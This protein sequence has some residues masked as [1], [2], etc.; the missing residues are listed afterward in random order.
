[1]SLHI[2]NR[3]VARSVSAATA[4]VL[5]AFI[6]LEYV[7]RVIDETT[8]IQGDYTFIKVLAYEGLRTFSRLYEV[9]P[10]VGLIG[11]LTGLGALANNSELIVMRSAGVSSLRLVWLALKPALVFM[12]VA[13]FIGEQIA[14]KA[15][16]FA[17]SYRGLLMHKSEVVNVDVGLWLRDAND[18]VYVGVVQPKGIMLGLNVFRFDIDGNL[19]GVLKAERATYQSD[20]WLL[21]DVSDTRFNNVNGLPEQVTQK[22]EKT[23]RWKSNLQPDLLSLAAVEPYDLKSIELINYIAYLK[24]QNL[25]SSE[26]EIALWN[27]VFY[28]F[29]MISLV[30]VGI[31]FVFGP[32]RQVTMGYRIFCGVLI[33]IIFKTVQDAVGPMSIVYGFTPVLAMLVPATV[34]ALMGIILIARVR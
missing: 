25:N 6:G 30:L 16:Q 8:N 23:Y 7:F 15:E 3:Y 9:M 19:V 26:Y 17:N 34:C 20:Y 12:L 27:K 28:P 22:I 14:P 11:C 5:F 18:F 31:S 21:E 4:V 1:M 29:I 32:L 13:M 24:A 33:G 10:Q 2:L